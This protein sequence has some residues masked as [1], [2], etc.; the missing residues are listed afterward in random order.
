MLD[1][2]RSRPQVAVAMVDKEWQDFINVIFA[3]P[4]D[5]RLHRNPEVK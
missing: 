4:E 2:S 5:F 3:D 1:F